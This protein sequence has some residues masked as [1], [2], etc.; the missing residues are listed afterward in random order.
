MPQSRHRHFYVGSHSHRRSKGRVKNVGDTT[1][2]YGGVLMLAA[3]RDNDRIFEEATGLPRGDFTLV[4]TKNPNPRPG[5][6]SKRN[7]RGEHLRK[8]DRHSL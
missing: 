2:L 1:G 4:A 7:F 3:T 6:S 5:R 8:L